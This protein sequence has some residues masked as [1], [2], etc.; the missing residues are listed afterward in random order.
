MKLTRLWQV[1]DDK[2]GGGSSIVRRIGTAPRRSHRRSPGH[3][4][5]RARQP[6]IGR[7]TIAPTMRNAIARLIRLTGT[8][9][10]VCM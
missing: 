3:L 6:A 4:R 7:A 5:N 1:A 9:S 2:V 8:T 10:S